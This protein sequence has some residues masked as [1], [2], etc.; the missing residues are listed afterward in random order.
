MLQV[1]SCRSLIVASV[2]L[3]PG[4][5]LPRVKVESRRLL[6][7]RARR[8]LIAAALQIKSCRSLIVA[9]VYLTPGN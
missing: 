9:S 6:S 3:T 7:H 1:K 8:S 5:G 4:N 2:S